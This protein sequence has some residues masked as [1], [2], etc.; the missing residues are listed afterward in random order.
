M[1][2]KSNNSV[3]STLKGFVALAVATIK[4]DDAEVI[5]LKIQKK[6]NNILT[7]QISMQN[8]ALNSAEEALE[9]AEEN[10]Q[11]ALI[12]RGEL[13]SNNEQYIERL[14]LAHLEVEAAKEE[15]E[16]IKETISQLE[17]FK[18]KTK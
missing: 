3:A 14:Q 9:T 5:A 4:G 17:E 15:I 11:N 13:I 6:A 18:T 8:L 12:N 1:S 2:N 10:F 7:T 16:A